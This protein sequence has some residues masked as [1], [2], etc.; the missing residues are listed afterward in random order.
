MNLKKE[1]FRVLKGIGAGLL[2]AVVVTIAATVFMFPVLM[3]LFW[4]D[5]NITFEAVVVILLILITYLSAF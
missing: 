1:F 5:G 3:G 4:L 2:V